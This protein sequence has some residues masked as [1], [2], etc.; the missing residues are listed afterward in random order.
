MGSSPHGPDARI[1]RDPESPNSS[2]LLLPGDEELIESFQGDPQ[3]K[4]FYDFNCYLDQN[5]NN[6]DM[7]T[8]MRL[9][10]REFPDPK[11]RTEFNN[12]TASWYGRTALL[13]PEIDSVDDF[14]TKLRSMNYADPAAR[15][16]WLWTMQMGSA[17]FVRLGESKHGSFFTGYGMRRA[18]GFLEPGFYNPETH[19]LQTGGNLQSNNVLKVIHGS[20][21]GID[22]N[23]ENA[24]PQHGTLPQ[25]GISE[26]FVFAQLGNLY[27]Y[28][29]EI[30]WNDMRHRQYNEVLSG[31]T[32]DQTRFGVV[33]RLTS[34]GTSLGVYVIYNCWEHDPNTGEDTLIRPEDMDKDFVGRVHRRCGNS[35]RFTVAKIAE[36]LSDLEDPHRTFDFRIIS[37]KVPILVNALQADHRGANL[38]GDF[39]GVGAGN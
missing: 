34:M 3:R 31:G 19:D 25:Q 6:V 12:F 16:H 15:A 27:A 9:I 10:M 28:N 5:G 32:W 13:K 1:G 21:L 7:M 30:E 23:T 4:K 33:L 18:P 20:L 26:P 38:V 8:R 29:G 22:K 17:P 14:L 35:Q 11:E 24:A 37:T 2:Q 39:D 36:N